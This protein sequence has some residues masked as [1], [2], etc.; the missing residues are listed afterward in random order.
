MTRS[1]GI[2]AATLLIGAG[3]TLSAGADFGEL[4]RG[5]VPVEATRIDGSVI[6]G[7]WLPVDEPG[8]IGL[9]TKDRREILSADDL[10]SLRFIDA[11]APTRSQEWAVTVWCDNGSIIPAD[12]IDG[13]ETAV[14]LKTPFAERVT[15]ALKDIAA[16]QWNRHQARFGKLMQEHLA[17]R[18]ESKD[19][20][21]ALRE[22]KP[23]SLE[24]AIEAI[25]GDGGSFN[26]RNRVLRFTSRNAV[27]LVLAAVAGAKPA[28]AV[29]VIDDGYRIAGHILRTSSDTISIRGVSDATISLSVPTIHEIRFNS[30]R[31]VYLSDLKPSDEQQRSVFDIRW[32]VRFDRAV[33]NRPLALNGR[34]YAKGL[35]VHAHSEITYQLD[36]AYRS[37]AATIGIDDFTRPAGHVIFQVFGDDRELF[38]SGPITGRDD[39][40]DVLV[41]LAGVRVIRL[42]VQQAEQLDIGDHAD[43]ANARLIK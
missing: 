42:V 16:I 33:S 19:T 14:R 11:F 29:C 8:K 2:I 22:N 35:G 39:P 40:R 17:A 23:R 43:W 21:I 3:Q 13:D 38:S 31:V 6:T 4:S 24:G 41:D 30:T 25:S 34:S 18:S 10:I 1:V 9:R 37:F 12:I 36:Q 26:F 28:P 27:G 32:P 5:A 15:V 20:L 7:E